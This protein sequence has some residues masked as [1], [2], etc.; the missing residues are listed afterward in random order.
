MPSEDPFEDCALFQPLT[1]CGAE[2]HA[3]C[4]ASS[5]GLFGMSHKFS[6]FCVVFVVEEL[7]LV[8]GEV[9]TDSCED[10]ELLLNLVL[11]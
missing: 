9:V 1:Y 11:L 2:F 4:M 7:K 6:Q 8:C 10:V 3:R 5:T